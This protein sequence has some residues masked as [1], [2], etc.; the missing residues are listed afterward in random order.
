[1]KPLI[2]L[3]ATFAVAF[4]S[5]IVFSSHWNYKLAGN[6]S[7]SVMLLFTAMGHFKF[8]KGMA[9]MMPD[10]IPFQIQI[11][12]VTG[13][14]EIAAGISLL[15][16]SLRYL[17]SILLIGF[18]VLILPANIHAAVKKVDYQAANFN[19]NGISYLW[20]RIPLQFL[21]IAW[22]WFFGIK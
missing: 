15:I 20:F 7:M 4:L 1:M 9:M 13:L 17:V 6:I 19:G 22:I 5:I 16:P 11:I 3:V 10:F 8:I 21:F 2:V 12:I 18:F 14:I